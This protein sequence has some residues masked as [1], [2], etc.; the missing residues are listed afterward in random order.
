MW[1]GLVQSRKG[2]SLVSLRILQGGLPAQ[3]PYSPLLKSRIRPALRLSSF[4]RYRFDRITLLYHNTPYI[5][6]AEARG[7]TAL[8]W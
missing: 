5:P 2:F 8:F 3:T 1:Q 6:I 7:F 4:L